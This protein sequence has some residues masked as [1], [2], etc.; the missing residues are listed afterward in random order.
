MNKKI[1]DFPDFEKLKLCID[2]NNYTYIKTVLLETLYWLNESGI[3]THIENI[4]YELEQSL[5]KNTICKN[6]DDLS[7]YSKTFNYYKNINKILRFI[8]DNISISQK[9]YLNKIL[10]Q[11]LHR[12][13]NKNNNLNIQYI[14]NM[15]FN[16]LDKIYEHVY[17][18]YMYLH[19]NDK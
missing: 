11:N 5:N 13:Y 2:T 8:Y 9:V 4:Y 17:R 3:K 19:N 6:M 1:I 14:F 12:T 10:I 15:M 18:M 16:K 7:K